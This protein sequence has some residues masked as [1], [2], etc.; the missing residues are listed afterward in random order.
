MRCRQAREPPKTP[1]LAPQA[2]G[3]KSDMA[4][5]DAFGLAV[6]NT[7]WCFSSWRHCPLRHSAVLTERTSVFM[8]AL[9]LV[10]RNLL[11]SFLTIPGMVIGV[12]AVITMVTLGNGAI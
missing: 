9:R 7:K 6:A 3:G 5:S 8:L 12:S 1:G 2:L 10:Q 11:R 4:A